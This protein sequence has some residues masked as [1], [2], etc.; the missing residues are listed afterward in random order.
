MS[1]SS[2]IKQLKAWQPDTQEISADVYRVTFKFEGGR[3]QAAY[4]QFMQY[5]GS[6]F[7]KISTP[8]SL[9]GNLSFE[10]VDAWAAERSPFPVIDGGRTWSLATLLPLSEIAFNTIIEATL[11]LQLQGD[12]F[13]E[14]IT[15]ADDW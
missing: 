7:V 14:E 15:G 2:V 9:K 8:I 11:A 3:Q 1:K 13:E 5:L 6:D 4:L 10:D 12:Y